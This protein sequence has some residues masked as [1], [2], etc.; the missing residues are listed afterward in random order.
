M[1]PDY[2]LPIY[3]IYRNT[4]DFPGRFVCRVHRVLSTGKTEIDRELFANEAS[5]EALRARLPP[6]LYCL[7]RHHWDDPV[8]VETWL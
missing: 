5:L 7:A 2:D 8:I 3:V 6:G 1:K 4:K